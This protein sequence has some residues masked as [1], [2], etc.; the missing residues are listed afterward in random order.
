MYGRYITDR[1]DLLSELLDQAGWKN[2]I[3]IEAAFFKP[4]GYR[5]PCERSGGFHV[6]IQGGC[7]LRYGKKTTRLEKGD[8]VFIIKGFHHDLVSTPQ[9][10]ALSVKS[11]LEKPAHSKPAGDIQEPVTSLVS[12]NYEVSEGPEHPFFLEL[13]D[14]ILVRAGEVPIAHPIHTTV[15]MLAREINSG[16]GSDLIIQRLTDILL[17]HAIRKWLRSSTSEKTGWANAFR[18][19]TILH[20]LELIH[21]DILTNWT[22]ESLARSVG[23]SRASLAARF[24]KTL[25]CTIIDYI[26]RQRLEKGRFL[27]EKSNISLEEVSRQVG[28][29][30]AFAFSKAF[31]R[32]YG[33][34]P[35]KHNTR[36]L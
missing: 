12:I 25:G 1:M 33:H 18:D 24:K 34:S 17:Y 14:L 9:G 13:P 2:N 20:T 4:W 7:Y 22:I 23:V 16:Y 35:R 6:I 5:F 11:L 31:K 15:E 32:V 19:E 27:T 30:S 8:L 29:S 10:K 3:L 26:S 21:R 36:A 28:Y